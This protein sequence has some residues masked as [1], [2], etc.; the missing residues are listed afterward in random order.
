MANAERPQTHSRLF[1]PR[2]V[3]Y[4][5]HAMPEKIHLYDT[6]LRD[7]AQSE[8]INL[9]TAD[10]LRIAVRLDNL[11][12]DY[13]EGG[14]P[15]ANPIDTAFFEQIRKHPFEYA[16]LAAFGSTHHAS[17]TPENDKTLQAIATC[18]ATVGT[19]FGKTCPQHVKIALGITRERNLEI[20][21]DSIAYLKQNLHQAFF[22]AEHFFDGYKRDAEYALAALAAAHEGGADTLVLCDTNGGS[23]PEE[24][25]AIIRDVR[26]RLPHAILGIHAHN[27]CELAVSNT[28][29]AIHAGARQVQGTI[30]GVGE[31]CGNAN[32]CSVIPNILLKT[33]GQCTCLPEGHLGRL[34]QTAAF[35]TDV[36]NMVPFHRQPFVGDSAF[37]HKGGVHVS[38]INKES[39]LY[40]HIEPET[41]GNSQRILMTEQGGKSNILSL[42]QNLGYTLSK[43]DP[44]LASLSEAIKGKASRGYDYAAAEASVELLMLRHLPQNPLPEFFR[45]L[46]LFVVNSKT[47]ADPDMIV[48]ATVKLDVR[49]QQAHTAA[50]GQGPVHALDKA[51]RKALLPFYPEIEDMKLTDYK[52]RVLTVKG[53]ADADGGTASNVRVLIESSD[54]HSNWTTVGVS[55]DIIDASWQALSESFI[56]HL[57]R[58]HRGL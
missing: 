19:I 12:I 39:S 36:A 25:T 31:R 9:S 29:A 2:T 24:I 7:G 52:V 11:G 41:V 46:R 14:W 3:Q 56:Y 42:A 54:S 28:L 18:G 57:Y 20:I 34:K 17:S 37:A 47:V 55:Y 13:I 38:A 32:L 10:K 23:M 27:D 40:E 8:D 6:T 22:D 1:A 44:I 50:G 43:D 30:N 58:R 51:L 26:A 53:E 5:T 45:L 48:E 21:R 33:G 16:R 35:V 4:S 49:G 15:G